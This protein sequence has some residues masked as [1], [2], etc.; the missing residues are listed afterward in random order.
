M[1]G[2]RSRCADHRR[3]ERECAVSDVPRGSFPGSLYPLAYNQVGIL[4]GF[5]SPLSFG[6]AMLRSRLWDIDVLINRMLVYGDLT[7]IVTA[8]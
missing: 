6:F 7:V 1:G 3:S 8:V 5:C 2:L 4:L